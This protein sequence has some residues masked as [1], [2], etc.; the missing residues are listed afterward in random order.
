MLMLLHSAFMLSMVKM[1]LKQMVGGHAFNSHGNYIVDHGKS[2]KNHGI[3]FLNS[4]GNPE[5]IICSRRG[6]GDI[7]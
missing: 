1:L 7:S 3:V 6:S 2:W 5:G 4:C